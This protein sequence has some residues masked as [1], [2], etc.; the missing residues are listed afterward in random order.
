MTSSNGNIS[1]VTGPLWGESTGHRWFRRQGQP[2]GA[3]IFF[4]WYAPEQTA[5]QTVEMLTIWD[6]MALVMRSLKC[7]FTSKFVKCKSSSSVTVTWRPIFVLIFNNAYH[8]LHQATISNPAPWTRLW[9][10]Q[11]WRPWMCNPILSSRVNF[12]AFSEICNKQSIILVMMDIIYHSIFAPCCICSPQNLYI[13]V[14]ITQI[15]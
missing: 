10:S 5:E 11:F 13:I 15:L 8:A 14:E 7:A 1:H 4:L 12:M 9:N 2:R 6:A 3:F